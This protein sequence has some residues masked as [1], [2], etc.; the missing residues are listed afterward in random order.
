LE[1]DGVGARIL[2]GV[3]HAPAKLH[4]AVV[5]RADLGDH[6]ERLAGA[7]ETP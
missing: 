2:R 4:V 1:L 7:D 5:V 3:H 6:P